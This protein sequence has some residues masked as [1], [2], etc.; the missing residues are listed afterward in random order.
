MWGLI[1]V[2]LIMAAVLLGLASMAMG[3][4]SPDALNTARLFLV[5]VGVIT[6]GSA[7]SMRPDL[8]WTWGIGSLACVLAVPGLPSHWDSF[9]LLF[10]VIAGLAASGAALCVLPPRWRYAVATAVLLYHFSG[11]FMATTSPPSTPW[12]SDQLFRRIYNPYLQFVYLRNAYHFYSPEP[13]PASIL[14]FL[15]KTETGEDPDTHKKQY[16]TKWLA[17]PKRPTDIRDPMGLGYYRLL[18]L[19]EQIARGSHILAIPTV[20]FE[21][22]EMWSR[23][24][25]VS[26]IIPF[27]PA[28]PKEIQYKLPNPDVARYLLPSYTSH[29]ILENTPDKA[30][31]AKTT[32]KVYRL[33]HRDIPADQFAHGQNPY[34]PG[35]Y[36]PFFLGEFDAFGNLVNPQEELLYWLL[37]IL[38]RQP[39]IDDKEGDPFKKEYYD[40]LSVHALKLS[41]DEVL[42][43]NENDGQVFNWSQLR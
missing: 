35:T 17:W 27:H 25:N 12:L 38:P 19:N 40:Y 7:V 23:R 11:I 31:A 32:V 24:F 26:N 41:R 8:W 13:G 37:P 30:T 42:K 28:E 4:S 9:Q 15:L 21:K 2:G 43:A 5:F 39:R 3:D 29:V 22:S 20:E 16:Q 34:H 10:A 14:V 1:G 36:R 18:S 33:E 6:A